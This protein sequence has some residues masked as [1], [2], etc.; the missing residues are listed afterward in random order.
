LTFNLEGSE[1]YVRGFSVKDFGSSLSLCDSIWVYNPA[2]AK[3]EQYYLSEPFEPNID[4]DNYSEYFRHLYG[5]RFNDL[6]SLFTPNYFS[7]RPDHSQFSNMNATDVARFSET[8]VVEL[9]DLSNFQLRVFY[10]EAIKIEDYERLRRIILSS[11]SSFVVLRIE[12]PGSIR[13][14]F[15]HIDDPVTS[16]QV[17]TD[18]SFGGQFTPDNRGFYLISENLDQLQYISL[19][20]QNV[21]R[22]ISLDYPGEGHVSAP[23]I[24]TELNLMAGY[25]LDTQTLVFWQ[26]DS[27]ELLYKVQSH[28]T[29]SVTDLA[30]SPDGKYLAMSYGTMDFT[31]PRTN[32][33]LEG[34]ISIWAIPGSNRE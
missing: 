10:P 5:E 33:S 16:F 12:Q 13:Y 31:P 6:I 11:D 7:L 27:G 29:V 8:G 19:D 22:T 14:V 26:L 17:V 25:L 4:Y 30:I 23:I 20:G 18:R 9:Y 15:C 21:T 34:F 32:E 2:N 1:L 3:V 28:S 24:S